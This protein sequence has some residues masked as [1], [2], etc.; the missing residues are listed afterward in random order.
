MFVTVIDSA[1]PN[2]KLFEERDL[3]KVGPFLLPATKSGCVQWT[4]QQLLLLLEG[5][6]RQFSVKRISEGPY[7]RYWNIR[8]PVG[9][10]EP[11]VMRLVGL[12]FNRGP[13][14]WLHQRLRRPSISVY[15][16]TELPFA[17]KPG[18]RMW[19]RRR[20]QSGLGLSCGKSPAWRYG[21]CGMTQD[22]QIG[23]RRCQQ[24]IR[25]I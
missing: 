1:P 23:D 20:G 16:Q 15:T 13:F 17:F 6:P 22:I 5:L 21:L 11:K 18:G 10:K 7:D 25:N 2:K 24:W 19:L 9:D 14:L 8:L 4:F 3:K 12:L